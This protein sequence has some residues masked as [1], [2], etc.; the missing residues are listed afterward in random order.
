MPLNLQK[1]KS[2]QSNEKKQLSLVRQSSESKLKNRLDQLSGQGIQTQSNI[3]TD[4]QKGV[5]QL[6]AREQNDNKYLEVTSAQKRKNN[7]SLS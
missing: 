4:T 5:M 7:M 1:M 3:L 6:I 2:L